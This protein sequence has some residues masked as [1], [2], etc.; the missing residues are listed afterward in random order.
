MKKLTTEE[1]IE[2]AKKIHG[3]KYDYSRV[4]YHGAFMDVC[5]ICKKHGAFLQKP[6]NHLGG[7]GCPECKRE[8]NHRKQAGTKEVFVIKAQK[9]H[10]DKYDYSKV[11][12]ENAKTKVCIV[13]PIHGDFWQT[14]NK[15]LGGS[16]CYFC[17]RKVRCST[18]FGVGINDACDCDQSIYKKWISMLKRCY[19]PRY[20]GRRSYIGCEVCDEWKRL[21]NFEKWYKENNGRQEWELDKDLLSNGYK[22]YSPQTCCFVPHEINTALTLKKRDNGLP[23]GVSEYG[24]KYI[25]KMNHKHLGYYDT[26]EDAF[27]AYKKAKEAH[28]KFLADKWK[29]KL[30]PR[31]Y[32]ALYK[33]KVEITR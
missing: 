1:F 4:E 2:K 7:K 22:V 28:I 30:E 23:V 26:I 24:D 18:V 15:H 16:G 13:C 11:E 12:Y 25:A 19:N 8:T 5:I 33:W 3:D 21:S 20:E 14:P 6:H 17:G 9:L 31:V 10:G 32:E 27:L 29:D